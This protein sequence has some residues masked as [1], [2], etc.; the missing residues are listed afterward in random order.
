[1]EETNF[2]EVSNEKIYINYSVIFKLTYMV[3][4]RLFDLILSMFF[5]VLLLPVIMVVKMIYLLNGDNH[6]IIFKQKRIG[7]NGK[8][9]NIYK[10]RTMVP[11][12]E[13][14]LIEMLKEDKYREEWN[15]NQKFN[16]DPRI[17]KIGNILRKT[18]LDELPQFLNV[19]KGDMALI[20]PRPLVPG[21]LDNHNGNHSIYESIRPGITGWWACNGR[22]D[23]TYEE[24]LRLEYY[25]IQNCSLHLDIKC[26]Y[27]TIAIIVKK[28]GAK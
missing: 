19:L 1:M 8:N 9:I 27:K 21:E 16:N 26:I 14:V 20:G 6:S 13:K 28:K 25:Y 23:I 10:F 17:T 7:K 15:L 4:K 3:F 5:C 18:S 24:R 22:S 2:N 11:N 12:A